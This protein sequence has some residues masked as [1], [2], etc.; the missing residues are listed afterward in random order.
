[1]THTN[2]QDSPLPGAGFP[3]TKGQIALQDEKSWDFSR[4]KFVQHMYTLMV[5]DVANLV[6]IG[7]QQLHHQRCISDHIQ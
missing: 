2:L 5:H 1:M 4:T 6:E 3:S 7:G